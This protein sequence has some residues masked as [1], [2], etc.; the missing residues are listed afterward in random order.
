MQRRRV[1]RLGFVITTDAGPD[2]TGMRFPASSESLPFADQ[3][4]VDVDAK[5][6]GTDAAEHPGPGVFE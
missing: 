3:R 5:D 6:L 4:A 2:G 1:P